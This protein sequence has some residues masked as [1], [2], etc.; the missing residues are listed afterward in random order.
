MGEQN[1]ETNEQID[2]PVTALRRNI[3]Q[4]HPSLRHATNSISHF[5]SLTEKR[6]HRARAST[7]GSASLGFGMGIEVEFAHIVCYHA[8]HRRSVGQDDLSQ[9]DALADVGNPF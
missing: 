2:K 8:R 1:V 5:E 3:V 9:G 4:T 7:A 6:R